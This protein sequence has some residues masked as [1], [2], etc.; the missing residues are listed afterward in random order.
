MMEYYFSIKMTTKDF[1][2]YYQG[3]SQNIIATTN[4]GVRVQFPAMHLRK[5]LSGAGIQGYF[6]LKTKNSKF[7]S[8]TKIY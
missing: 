5:Y 2:P 8:L 4:E 3:L 6:C 7:L 1:M